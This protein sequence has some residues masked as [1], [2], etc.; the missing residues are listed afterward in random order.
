MARWQGPG[1]KEGMGPPLSPAQ[2]AAFDAFGFLHLRQLY[3][4]A[5]TRR[6]VAEAQAADLEEDRGGG[7]PTSQALTAP[8]ERR[9]V[10]RLVGPALEERTEEDGRRRNERGGATRARGKRR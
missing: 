9:P 7:T 5:E 4:P 2:A 8:L 6:I 1:S 10:L 3:S